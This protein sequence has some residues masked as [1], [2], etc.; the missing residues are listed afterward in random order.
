MGGARDFTMPWASAAGRPVH[1]A[2]RAGRQSAQ[3][4]IA[5]AQN[6]GAQGDATGCGEK[7]AA[8]SQ[9][10]QRVVVSAAADRTSVYFGGQ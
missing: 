6:T 10:G 3:A 5:A 9:S 8:T 2:H 7:A 4:R 1:G